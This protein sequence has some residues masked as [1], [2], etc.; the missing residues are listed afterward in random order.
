M[1]E[2]LEKIKILRNKYTDL[3]IG[4]DGGITCENIELVAKSGA[5]NIISGTGIYK[6]AD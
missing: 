6:H 2:K 3:N 4:I 1:E 5:N